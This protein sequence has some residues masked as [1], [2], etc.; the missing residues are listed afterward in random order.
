[1]WNGTAAILYPN[2]TIAMTAARIIGTAAFPATSARPISPICVVP[3]RPK[4]REK[5]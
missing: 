5:P 2:P 3:E 4:R 1:M